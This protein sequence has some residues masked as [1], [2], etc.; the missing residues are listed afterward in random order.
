[1]ARF[2]CAIKASQLPTPA[3]GGTPEVAIVGR[4]NVGKST[5]LNVLLGVQSR[6]QAAATGDKPGV[7]Q[8]LDFYR[9]GGVKRWVGRG[10]WGGCA[11]VWEMAC[12]ETCC[13]PAMCVPVLQP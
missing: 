10:R 6:K 9:L 2:C 4:S 8:S 12:A 5:L 11:G 13:S 7:T 3:A 1:V